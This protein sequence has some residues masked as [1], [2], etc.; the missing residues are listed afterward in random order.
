[1]KNKIRVLTI[2]FIIA[3]F[4]LLI[5]ACS[6]KQNLVGKWQDQQ[7]GETL[8]FF[9]DGTVSMTTLGM[10]LTGSYTVL[11]AKNLKIN[12]S[13]LFG[14]GGAQIYE[15]SVSGNTLTLTFSGIAEQF[16]K[17]K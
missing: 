1:M 14:I 3:I 2:I 17:V 4:L 5:S 16:T 11:D 8:E 7:S 9:K 15:Y 12:I 6:P 13:G 10:S